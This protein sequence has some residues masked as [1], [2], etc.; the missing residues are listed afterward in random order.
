M[1]L[2]QLVAERPLACSVLVASAAL[3]GGCAVAL[4]AAP[5]LNLTEDDGAG[6]TDLLI[7][8][9]TAAVYRYGDDVD[10]PHLI[11]FSPSGKQLLVER[12]E[13]YP[14][15]RCFWF[16][17]TVQL[18][19]KRKVS[20]YNAW[21]SRLDKNDPKSAFKDHIR[22]VSYDATPVG[23][24]Q[25]NV[26]MQLVWEMDQDVPVLDETRNMRVI[27]L[28]N[29]EYFL[30]VTFTLTA[31][32]GDV[33]FVSDA[34]HYAWP[35]LRMTKEFSVQG[36]GT[37]TNSEGGVNQ[38]ATNMKPATWVDYSNTIDGVTEGVAFFS[39]PDNEHPHKWLTLD[40]GCFGPRRVDAKSGKK[41][42]A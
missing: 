19:G 2:R 36:G 41:F 15:H 14:H 31:A 32:H 10:L 7:D 4:P 25:L 1:S 35:Y 40:Y 21:Y 22:H 13:P 27:A 24:E 9:N 3:A 20:F 5:R 18:E 6:K 38:K 23:D 34:V 33:A 16:A 39:H 42:R 30:D 8:G 37:I 17:D 26:D 12:T 29:G 28:G 11:L